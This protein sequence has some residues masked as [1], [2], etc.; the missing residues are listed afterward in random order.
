MN[1]IHDSC[2]INI[3]IYAFKGHGCPATCTPRA[4]ARPNAPQGTLARPYAPQGTLSRPYAP[5]GT[6]ARSYAPQGTLAF[7]GTHT[8]TQEMQEQRLLT[9]I[10]SYKIN[11]KRISH[12]LFTSKISMWIS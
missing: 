12:V 8:T 5:Q 3:N 10:T 1:S 4:L 6:L 11:A 9:E 2:S 7:T